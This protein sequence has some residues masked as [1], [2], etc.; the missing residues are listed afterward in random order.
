MDFFCFSTCSFFFHFIGLCLKAVGLRLWW[1]FFFFRLS[2][3]FPIL[4]AL[5]WGRRVLFFMDCFCFSTC[6]FFSHFIGVRLWPSGSGFDGFLL[7]FDLQLL[8]L[9]HWFWL[10]AVGF[11]LWWISFVFRLAASFP[12]SLVLVKGRRV[13]VLMDFFYFFTCSFFPH[14]IAFGIRPS[15]SSFDGF[16]FVFRLAASFP[17]LLPLVDGR[18][19]QALM[20]FFCFLIFS[21][22]SYFIAF[23]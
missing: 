1:I 19:V 23:N 22:F 13:Q 2:A 8:F 21:F 16:F 4:F 10:K 12:I 7:F 20:D 6:S 15:G 5:V 9:F 17:I 14:F 11:R 18:R 3:T